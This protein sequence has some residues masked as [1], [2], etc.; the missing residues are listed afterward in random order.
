VPDVLGHFS[1]H[2]HDTQVFA[3]RSLHVSCGLARS[4]LGLSCGS[5][6]NCR[7]NP[8]CSIARNGACRTAVPVGERCW[9]DSQVAPSYVQNGRVTVRP[10]SRKSSSTVCFFDHMATRPSAGM[11]FRREASFSGSS[12]SLSS[13]S[14]LLHRCSSFRIRGSISG[15]QQISQLPASLADP[16]Q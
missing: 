10:Y 15:N 1:A 6:W 4:P 3:R 11:E 12:S 5:V 2:G 7:F 13:S 14:P 8:W 9:I 16:T